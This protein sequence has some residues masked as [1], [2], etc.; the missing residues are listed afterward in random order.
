MTQTRNNRDLFK[1]PLL[2]PDLPGK[3]LNFEILRL[4][5]QSIIYENLI[6]T[7]AHFQF[8]WGILA[9]K[10]NMLFEVISPCADAIIIHTVLVMGKQL[11]NCW[12]ILQY[13]D[14]DYML[15]LYLSC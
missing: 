5:L 11:L 14:I 1:Y 15:V 4:C 9:E 10:F 6:S 8:L 7:E 3:N 13:V 12:L 2:P